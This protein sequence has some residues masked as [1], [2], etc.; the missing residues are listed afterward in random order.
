MLAKLRTIRTS[1][2]L[3]TSARRTLLAVG[4]TAM[5]ASAPAQTITT[6]A[7]GGPSSGTATQRPLGL[8]YQIALDAARQPLH[9]DRPPAHGGADQTPRGV[10]TVVA[11][12]G[13]RRL[14]RRRRARDERE[15]LQPE[16]GGGGHDGQRLHLRLRPPTGSAGSTPERHHHHDRGDGR[17]RAIPATACPR[18]ARMLNGPRHLYFSAGFLY[19]ADTQNHR[20]AGSTSGTGDITFVA[21]NGTAGFAD[22]SV[23]SAQ[24]NS[25]K[26]RGRGRARQQRLRGRHLE[27]ARAEDQRAGTSPPSRGR[28]RAASTGTA[29]RPRI[30]SSRTR[31]GWRST[32]RPT[33]TSRTR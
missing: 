18:R 15:R 27:P 25:P 32:A 5:A 8:P 12:N 17:G 33:Y 14:E 28:A 13:A 23:A 4:L 19:I 3:R 7:G 11:G 20:S 9:R 31:K 26:R 10:L 2:R 30:S 24:F 22:G 21:G 6:V 29:R 1:L 16:R